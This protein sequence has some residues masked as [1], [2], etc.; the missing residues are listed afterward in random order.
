[1]ATRVN[2]AVIK[3]IPGKPTI[4]SKTG[5]NIIDKI[6][7][8]PIVTPITAIDLVRTSSRVRSALSAITAEDTAPAP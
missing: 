6:K 1:M 2:S 7:V 3:N 4:E 5:P 8:K